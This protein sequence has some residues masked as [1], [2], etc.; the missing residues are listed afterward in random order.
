[1]PLLLNRQKKFYACA[2]VLI[3]M[4]LVDLLYIWQIPTTTTA[5]GLQYKDIV[6]GSGESPPVG[7]QVI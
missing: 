3:E 6:G 1:M 4:Y 2:D 7:F 5:S